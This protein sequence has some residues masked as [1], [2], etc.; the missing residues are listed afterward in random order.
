M[1]LQH[2]LEDVISLENSYPSRREDGDIFATK[3]GLN[4]LQGSPRSVGSFFCDDNSLTTLEGGPDK[5]R[6]SFF[7]TGNK[8]TS[9]K[10]SPQVVQGNFCCD[11]NELT[12]LV[13]ITKTIGAELHIDEG[14]PLAGLPL[15]RIGGDVTVYSKGK[16]IVMRELS[17]II[18]RYINKG[19]EGVVD[20]QNELLAHGYDKEAEFEPL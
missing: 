16:K 9:L 15:I 11:G 7:V 3:M 20:L 18:N 1:N 6:G 4:S 19:R 12:S 2:L 17:G 13:G 8:L 5:V 14:I 10:G